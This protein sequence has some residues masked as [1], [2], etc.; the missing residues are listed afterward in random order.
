MTM[1][2]N[3]CLISILQHCLWILLSSQFLIESPL[4]QESMGLKEQLKN[5]PGLRNENHLHLISCLL[6][7]SPKLRL[8]TCSRTSYDT[9]EPYMLIGC[10]WL[11]TSYTFTTML[12]LLA[13]CCSN[14]ATRDSIWNTPPRYLQININ[15]SPIAIILKCY[16]VQKSWNQRSLLLVTR[17]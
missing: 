12:C 5:H 14:F 11:V 3:S 6:N 2:Q 7:G 17:I 15:R 1:P 16:F 8:L 13:S 4:L 9:S 10:E